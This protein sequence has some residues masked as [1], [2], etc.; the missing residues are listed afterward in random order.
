MAQTTTDTA[1]STVSGAG[2]ASSFSGGTGTEAEFGS[3]GALSPTWWEPE[4]GSEPEPW[5]TPD[6]AF[7]RFFEWTSNR[8]IE[9]WDHQEEALMDL[10]AGDHVILGTPTGSGK[11][12]VALGMLFMG[13]AQGKRCYYTAPIKALVSEKFFDLVQVLG[14]DNVGMITGDTHINTKAPVICCTAEILANDA[15][16]EGEDADV[17]CVAMDE[18]HYFADPDR[19]WAWQVPLLTLPHTQFMLMSATLG[20]VTAIAAS[21]EEHTGATCDLVVDAPR[22]VPLSYDYVTTSLE[23]TVE[24]AMRRGEAPLYIVHFSQDAALATAQSLANFGIASK[25]QREAIKEAAKGTSFSTA[26]GKILKRLLGCGVG[27][28]HAGMLPRYRLLVERLAQQGLLPVICGTDT[29]GVGINVPIHTVVLTALTKFDGY[30]MRRLRAREF[31]QIAGRAGRSGFDTEGMVI[32]EA[33]EH[34]IENAKLMAKAGVE[35]H[36]GRLGGVELHKGVEHIEFLEVQVGNAQGVTACIDGQVL[37]RVDAIELK[38][39]AG[40]CRGV[41]AVDALG[42]KCAAGGKV[43][44]SHVAAGEV[45]DADGMLDCGDVELFERDIHGAHPA[46][47]RGLARIGEGGGVLAIERIVELDER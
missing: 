23:G 31:H 44:E 47:P 14:R 8:G 27:V 30:K 21:L 39:A 10:A 46:G 19:G 15:L 29:L 35:K 5:L 42:G 12:L 45:E 41:C 22:P 33:P 32:A 24:L 36:V 3:L 20:D 17:G 11:S 6:Q 16:R 38:R 34:E 28:H 18:F 40:V 25:E 13:M 26:F 4:D 7:E 1:A 43:L 9:L 37:A 2:A